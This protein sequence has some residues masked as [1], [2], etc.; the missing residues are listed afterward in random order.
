MLEWEEIKHDNGFYLRRTKLFNGWLVSAIYDQLSPTQ[1]SNGY[2]TN[3][4]GYEWHGSITFV[5]D[6]NHEWKL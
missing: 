1:Y 6:P 4:P 3:S 5:P 2:I